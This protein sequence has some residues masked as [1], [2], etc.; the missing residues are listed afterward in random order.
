MKLRHAAALALGAS[1]TFSCLTSCATYQVEEMAVKSQV[2]GVTILTYK[3]GWFAPIGDEG[4]GIALATSICNE[5]GYSGATTLGEDEQCVTRPW[6]KL[7][8]GNNRYFVVTC[9][10]SVLKASYDCVDATN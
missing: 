6:G 10:E 2:H 4:Q 5:R 1:I 9:Y 7:P 3:D 8:L